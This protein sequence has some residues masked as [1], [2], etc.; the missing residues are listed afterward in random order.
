MEDL[1]KQLSAID[2][3]AF[4]LVFQPVKQQALAAAA[5]TTPFNVLFLA[6]SFFI[7]AAAVML[8]LLLFR[9]GVEQRAGQIGILLAVG[10]QAPAS[11]ADT[12][13][14]RIFDRLGRQ[15]VGR[16]GGHRLCRTVAPGSAHLVAGRHRYAIFAVIYNAAQSGHWTGKRNPGGNGRHRIFGATASAGSNPGVCWQAKS[17][18]IGN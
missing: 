3:A 11:A 7:I 4:G 6:F 9:L 16:A 1:E 18:R 15:P 14:R 2:P 17:P 10:T 5:G 8:V 13:G 12:V